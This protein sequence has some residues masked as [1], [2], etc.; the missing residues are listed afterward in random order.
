SAAA[1]GGAAC[2][3]TPTCRATGGSISRG[4]GR[5]TSRELPSRL[6]L[7]FGIPV[8]RQTCVLVNE[9]DRVLVVHRKE[10]RWC[11][12]GPHDRLRLRRHRWI[13]FRPA[14][15]RR[16]WNRIDYDALRRM[17]RPSIL[18]VDHPSD[19]VAGV[20]YNLG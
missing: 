16:L 20:E 15:V 1:V 14:G 10:V 4:M 8:D 5:R 9:I 6:I 11:G 13:L 7:H 17:K 3:S 18:R 2:A 19:R 12:H